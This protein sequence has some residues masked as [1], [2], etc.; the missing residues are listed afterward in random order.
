MDITPEKAKETVA[1]ESNID[2]INEIGDVKLIFSQEMYLE[3]IFAD[4]VFTT[5]TEYADGEEDSDSYL[6]RL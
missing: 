1:P 5:S 6:R 3:E 2:S 4:F